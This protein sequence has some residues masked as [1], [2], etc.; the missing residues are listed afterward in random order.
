MDDALKA[1]DAPT[2]S[3]QELLELLSQHFKVDPAKHRI[4][5]RFRF[6]SGDFGPTDGML[7]GLVLGLSQ[8]QLI[9]RKDAP[10]SKEATPPKRRVKKTAS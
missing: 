9:P 10:T 6:A 4:H 3:A 8:V 5:L 2:V 7:P 1:T